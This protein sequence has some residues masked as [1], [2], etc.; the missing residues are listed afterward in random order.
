MPRT[1]PLIVLAGRVF[2]H[3]DA[4]AVAV[5]G[6]RIER[7]GPHREL[8]AEKPPG[9]RVVGNGTGLICPGFHEAHG[10]LVHT[11]LAAL[12]VDLAGCSLEQI[13]PRLRARLAT[14]AAGEWVVANG[15]APGTFEEATSPPRAVLDTWV[16]RR[17]ALLRA[18]DHHAVFLNTAGLARV[19]ALDGRP[20]AHRAYV[21]VD[22]TGEPTGRM[23]ED[24]AWA[25]ESVAAVTGPD[26]RRAATR[27]AVRAL[28][29]AGIVAFHEMSG[30][31]EHS[32]LRALDAAGELDLDVFATVSE[33][34]LS[35][36]AART[37][38]ERLRIVGTKVFLDGALGSKTAALLEPYEGMGDHCGLQ[39]LT[40]EHALDIVRRSADVG[41]PGYLH[42]IGDAAVRSALD[43]FAYERADDGPVLRHRVEHA[44]MIHADDLPRF[45]E[46]DVIASLQPIHLADD[47]PWVHRLWGARSNRAFPLRRLVDSGARL[48]LGSDTPIETF[49]VLAGIR[50][51]VERR[52]RDGTLLHPE[53]ALTVGEALRG[54]TSGAAYAVG[55]EREFGEVQPGRVASLTLLTHDIEYAPETL[56]ACRVAATIVRG[57]VVHEA[58]EA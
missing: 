38:G 21:D 4:D 34:D 42:A 28:H 2:G 8:L 37:S 16:P 1:P 9:T 55:A 22:G 41:L 50:A 5:S 15:V 35:D 44:Q 53:E 56:H 19:G 24:A 25:A 48:A 14:D 49:D 7:V 3:P 20:S 17:P 45:A 46:L 33:G 47:A 11:G 10:H 40:F 39:T 58:H 51:A 27:A 32:T 36:P 26:V 43:V 6:E 13:G 30:S 29:A 12:E 54:Y 23:V 57:S 52:G 31:R 18:H